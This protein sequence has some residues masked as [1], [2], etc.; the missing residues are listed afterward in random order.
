MRRT[1]G[2]FLAF[3]GEFYRRNGPNAREGTFH[4][5]GQS[6]GIDSEKQKTRIGKTRSRAAGCAAQ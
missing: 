3:L 4:H 5:P 2:I 1:I 6:Y